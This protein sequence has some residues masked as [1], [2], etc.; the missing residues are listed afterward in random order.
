VIPDQRLRFAVVDLRGLRVVV[1]VAEAGSVTQAAHVLHQSSSATSHTLVRLE[2]ELGVD[3]FDRLPQGMALTD[4][5]TVFVDA[6]R[7]ALHEAE[8]ARASVDAVK[9]VLT[10][11]VRTA[12]VFWFEIPLADLIG[13]FSLR[14]PGVVVRVLAPDNTEAVIGSVRSGACDVGFVWSVSLPEDLVGVPV[15]TDPGVVV[16]PEGHRLASHSKVTVSD[17]ADERIVAPLERSMMRPV[18]DAMFRRHG[19][20]PHIA[21]EAATNDM[22]LELARAGVGCTVTVS[23]SVGS[24]VGRGAVA[25]EIADQAPSEILLVSRRRQDPTPSARAFRDLAVARFSP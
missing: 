12:T 15:F 8:V 5:G 17:L 23:S 1:A 13:A 7:R 20:E 22:A 3:L 11:Q 10:G 24:V 9:G 2:A 16:V 19:F 18:F 6:A 21:A 4:A 25:V 14:H